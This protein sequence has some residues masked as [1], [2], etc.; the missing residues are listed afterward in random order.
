MTKK[1][2]RKGTSRS[3]GSPGGLG[4]GMNQMALMSQFQKMQD[5]MLKAREE[6]EKETI[7]VSAAGGAVKIVITGHQRIQSI[8]I[9]KAAFDTS[10]EDW[11]ED[12]QD[13]LV[14]AFNQAIEQSQALDAERIEGITGDMGSM[15]PGGLGG[16]L[17]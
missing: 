4:G 13:T 5:D 6:L 17:G 10:E 2:K 1:I 12:L 15:L 8:A 14:A 16:L 11:L 7:E 9:D 3:G